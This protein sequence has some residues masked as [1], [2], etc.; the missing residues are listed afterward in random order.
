MVFPAKSAMDAESTIM[1]KC[2]SW[3]GGCLE[4]VPDCTSAEDHSVVIWLNAPSVG[5]IPSAKYE[6]YLTFVTNMMAD[7]AKNGIC[8]IIFPN[9]ASQYERRTPGTTLLHSMLNGLRTIH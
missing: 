2:R 1:P 3:M 6:F 4:D 8:L 5:I 7:Y 9:R